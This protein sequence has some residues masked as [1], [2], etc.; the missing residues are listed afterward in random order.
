M[1]L[2]LEESR[3]MPSLTE[4]AGKVI[5]KMLARLVSS[6][7]SEILDVMANCSRSLKRCASLKRKCFLVFLG[8]T[9]FRFERILQ[10]DT[11][12]IDLLGG[13]TFSPF[14]TETDFK[15]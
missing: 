2:V 6:G 15:I 13:D 12:F 8:L 1:K 14:D 11:E 9:G 3:H 10:R 5:S 4:S 7:T